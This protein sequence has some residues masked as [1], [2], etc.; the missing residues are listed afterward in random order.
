MP[1]RSVLMPQTRWNSF[2]SVSNEKWRRLGHLWIHA[3]ELV[4]GL[5]TICILRQWEGISSVEFEKPPVW[6]GW[7]FRSDPSF[8]S[9]W[10]RGQKVLPKRW[11][12]T[13]MSWWEWAQRQ[14]C[15]DLRQRRKTERRE[16]RLL[17][18]CRGKGAEGRGWG[19]WFMGEQTPLCQQ[20][21]QR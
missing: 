7:D 4:D 14:D 15:R 3:G 17:V 18:C 9:S 1:P 8:P 19:L 6:V 2:K 13:W 21:P 10:V 16:V 11:K 20:L 5:T 12:G